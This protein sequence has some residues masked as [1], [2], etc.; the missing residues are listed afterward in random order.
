MSRL[1]SR[2]LNLGLG[3]LGSRF[4][5]SNATSTTELVQTTLWDQSS[6]RL[7][8][9]KDSRSYNDSSFIYL[10]SRPKHSTCCCPAPKGCRHTIHNCDVWETDAAR[11]SW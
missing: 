7:P 4:S 3:P 11:L 5:S 8:V 1:A 10:P 9:P 6:G 2:R